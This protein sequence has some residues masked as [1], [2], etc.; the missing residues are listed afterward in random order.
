MSTRTQGALKRLTVA[1]ALLAALVAPGALAVAPAAAGGG[2]PCGLATMAP[3]QA[4]LG[5]LR[6]SMLCLVNRVREHYGLDE[7]SDN[8]QLRRSATGHS[9]DMVE[10]RYFSHDGPAGSTVDSRVTRAGY[11][12][13]V[14]AYFV[15]ENIGGGV[16]RGLGS[17]LAVFRAWMHSPPHRENILDPEFHDLGVGVAR[18]YPD[19]GGAAAATYTLDLGMRN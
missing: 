11:L 8:T 15:G 13:R 18:G 7:L 12:A 19:G 5:D 9:I 17:P 10:H 14:S 4:S 3:R 1:T 6:E 2:S 16:G